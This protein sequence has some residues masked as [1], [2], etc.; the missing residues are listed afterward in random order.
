MTA[1]AFF[2]ASHP[3]FGVCIILGLVWCLIFLWH[4]KLHKEMLIAGLLGAA[5]AL[6]DVLYIP[7]YWSPNFVFP[8]LRLGFSHNSQ[9]FG[10]ALS[11]EDL[12]FGFFLAGI[13]SVIYE[14]FFNEY[15]VHMPGHARHIVAFIVF[16]VLFLVPSYFWPEKTI[17]WHVLALCIGAAIV[18]FQRRDLFRKVI[19]A[20]ILFMCFYGLIFLLMNFLY[21]GILIAAHYNVADLSGYYVFGIPIEELL[22]PF[23]VGA[24]GSVVYEYLLG[25]RLRKNEDRG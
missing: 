6:T 21:G 23:G 16:V 19:I 7:S 15:P 2:L 18:A 22:F 24:F 25:F 12:L 9:F 20:G 10:I 17:Y 14:L 13:A 11:L 4:R 1:T 5:A 8:L 3:Y